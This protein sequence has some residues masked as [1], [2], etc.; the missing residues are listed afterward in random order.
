MFWR[1]YHE[2]TKHSPDSLRRAQH[3]LDWANMPNPFRHYEGAPL[4]DLPADPP[5]PQISAT[6]VLRQIAGATPATDGA[7]FLSQLMFYSASISASKKVESTGSVYA[8]RVNPS[9][10][11]LHPTEFHFC[12]RGLAN[13]PDGLYHYRPSSHMAE[14]RTLGDL[15]SKLPITAAPLVFVLTTIAWREAWKYRDRAYRYCLHDIGHAW[16]S[17][18]LAAQAMGCESF[19]V[20]NFADDSVSEICRLNDDEWPMLII[21]LHGPS[22]P[23]E[24]TH[25]VEPLDSIGVANVLS[26]E[27]I[28]YPLIEKI[29][30]ATKIQSPAAPSLE[31]QPVINARGD[32]KLPPPIST[33]LTFGEVVR[34][35]RS[36]L[37]FRGG[38]E[39]ISLAQLS[40]LLASTAAPLHAD[41]AVR[42]F[43]QLYLYVHRVDGLP[44]GVYRFWPEHAELESLKPGDQRLVAA[45]LSLGQDL[46]GDSCVAFSMIGDFESATRIF[47][48]RGY[49]YVHFEAGA[50]GHRMYLASEALGFRATGIGAFFDHE[51]HRYLNLTPQVGQVVYHFAVGHPIHDPRLEA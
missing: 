42:R 11:N 10:G 44:P 34:T 3:F 35:R 18:A 19:A 50:L 23:V 33:T 17:L 43:V 4:L 38:D 15:V 12:T 46:A 13:W 28:S 51:V 49:R 2:L 45:A 41:F 24:S 48:N 6:D 30:S 8:L 26:A 9:S 29:Q 32:I 47:G 14:Q 16:Q 37:G 40:T 1:E 22:I 36:A 21:A 7:A 39:S 20:G 31:R 27:F 5:P 25:S